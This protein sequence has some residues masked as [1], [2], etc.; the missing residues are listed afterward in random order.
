MILLNCLVLCFACLFQMQIDDK[1]QWKNVLTKCTGKNAF[2][3]RLAWNGNVARRENKWKIDLICSHSK[4][5]LHI[6]SAPHLI[7]RSARAHANSNFQMQCEQSI[8]SWVK[9]SLKRRQV[10]HERKYKK[11]KICISCHFVWKLTAQIGAVEN[12]T[13]QF[14]YR[15]LYGA[16]AIQ[17]D[18]NMAAWQRLFHK[19]STDKCEFSAFLTFQLCAVAHFKPNATLSN[20]HCL[21]FR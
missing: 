10:L 12:C 13:W 6:A 11:K 2:A 20:D 4:N 8:Y 15:W 14:L 5:C 18:A 16:Y 19:N 9:W 17:H 7:N 3:K 21:S 1:L